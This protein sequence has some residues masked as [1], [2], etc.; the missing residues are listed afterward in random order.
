MSDNESDI[1]PEGARREAALAD[2]SA[3]FNLRT[4]EARDVPALLRLIRALAEYER[5]PGA[6]IATE[7]DLLREGF[8]ETP[9]F[10]ATLAERD[11]VPIGFSLW[12]YNYSTW[13]GR[14]G[15]YLE[16]L[17]VLPGERG[18]GVGRALLG[19][20]GARALRENLGRVD[21]AVLDWN[22]P[23][24]DFYR[25]IGAKEM[26]EWQIM[27]VEGTDALKKLAR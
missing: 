26:S 21:W 20:L 17:F 13:L 2:N 27:R 11:G 6:V 22:Q 19:E 4:A 14:A 23:A 12:F 16:D 10:H 18:R 5:A 25:A 24:I 15:I 8:G 1:D 9:R 7:A 3:G